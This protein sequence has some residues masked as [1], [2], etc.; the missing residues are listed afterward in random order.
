MN[1]EIKYKWQVGRILRDK[2]ILPSKN[3]KRISKV[4]LET[5]LERLNIRVILKRPKKKKNV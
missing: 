2:G 3:T 4:K 1:N 5:E